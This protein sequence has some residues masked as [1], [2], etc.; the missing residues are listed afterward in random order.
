MK[1]ADNAKMAELN[2]T[3]ILPREINAT[4]S[5]MITMI[6]FV[7]QAASEELDVSIP[8]QK[9]NVNQRLSVL[10]YAEQKMIAIYL[11]PKLFV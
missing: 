4:L 7:L 5:V 6:R 9:K 1:L 2:H 10:D 3:T 11:I 8:S